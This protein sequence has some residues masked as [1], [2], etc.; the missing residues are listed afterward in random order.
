FQ[1]HTEDSLHLNLNYARS[2]FQQPNQFD[3][4]A[5]GQDQ[6]A[7]INTLNIA[8][9][10]THIFNPQTVLTI[11]GFFRQDRY[12]YFPNADAVLDFPA[13]LAKNRL[14]TNLGARADLS[15]VKGA[16]NIKAGV[17]LQHW[18]LKEQF[19]LGLT[20]PTFNPPCNDP[21]E[22]PPCALSGTNANYLPGL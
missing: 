5:G 17:Q 18:F 19:N 15:Y 7:L 14:L 9:G 22:A 2:W 12:H 20:D 11:K 13:T 6:R 8:P 10:W 21:S 1:P 16:H 3:Q 4:Q